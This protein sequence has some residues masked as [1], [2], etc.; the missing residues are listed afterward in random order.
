MQFAVLPTLVL[1]IASAVAQDQPVLAR[2]E[3]RVVDLR[4]EPLPAAVVFV[5]AWS[6][7]DTVLARATAD[8]D[9]RFVLG[10]VPVRDSWGIGAEAPGRTTHRTWTVPGRGPVTVQL[11]EAVRVN[12]RLRN[13]AGEPV[14]GATVVAD[15][16]FARELQG[17]RDLAVTDAEGRFELP[18]VPLGVVSFL[19]VV[20]GEGLALLRRHVTADTVI[21]LSPEGKTVDTTIAVVGLPPAGPP[22]G[23]A[24]N[25]TPFGGAVRALPPPWQRAALARDGRCTLVGLP[26][27]R[28]TV[29][30]E[31]PGFLCHP[32]SARLQPGTALLQFTAVARS[33]PALQ[34]SGY[35][36]D[37][38]GQPVPG[39]ALELRGTN[40]AARA[41]AVTG[42]DGRWRFELPVAPGNVVV[43]RVAAG[44]HVLDTRPPDDPMVLLEARSAAQYRGPAEPDRTL[45][46]RAIRGA[47]VA[48]K[49]LRPDGGPATFAVVRLEESHPTRVPAWFE[50]ARVTTDHD[51]NYTFRGVHPLDRPVRIAVQDPAGAASGEPFELRA[52]GASVVR[53][54][55]QLAPPATVEGDVRDRAGKPVAGLR[56]WLREW[57]V[58]ANKQRSGSLVEVLT[59]SAGRFRFA[60]VAPGGAT[61]QVLFEEEF[62][63]ANAA[64]P[65]EV[66]A[67][68]THRFQLTFAGGP[69][70]PPAAPPIPP[71]APARPPAPAPEPPADER[72]E[73]RVVDLGGEPLAA[74]TVF[75]TAW[76]DPDTVLARAVADGDGRFVLAKVPV[77]GVWG[78]GASAP[79][80]ATNRVQASPGRGPVTVQLPEAVVVRGQLRNRAG[81]PV[82]GATVTASLFHALQGARDLAV[83]DADGRFELARVPLGVVW[84]LAVVPGEGIA[85]LQQHVTGPATIGLAPAPKTVDATIEVAG[86]P[87][88][89]P[90]AGAVVHV[91]AAATG[92]DL[93]PPPWVRPPLDRQGRCVLAGVPEWKLTMTPEIPGY[94]CVPVSALFEFGKVLRFTAV[95]RDSPALR[96]HGQVHDAEG[97]PIAGLALALHAADAGGARTTALTDSDGRWQFV[98]PVAPGNDVVIQAAP[99]AWVLDVQPPDHRTLPPPGREA[100]QYRGKAEPGQPLTLR[101]IRAATVTGRVLR[102]DGRPAALATVRLE[103][104]YPTRTPP[105]IWLAFTTTDHAG[106]YEFRNVHALDR[107]L[108]IAVRDIE[109]AAT[110]QPFDL[111]R[112]GMQVAAPD[113]QLAPGGQVEG[114]VRDPGGKPV[115]GLR[116]R[117]QE[118][119][120]ARGRA[121]GA[122]AEA[123][124]DSA[125][126]FRFRGVAPGA[127]ALQVA[128]AQFTDPKV[129]EPFEVDAGK[130]HSFRLTFVG[131]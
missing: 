51:G 108:R 80:R 1:A 125:G 106:H 104:S 87:A 4:G 92:I 78:V 68:S 44:D 103:E 3:G 46:L 102:A 60:G 15:L 101:A 35:V 112:A 126:R 93:L 28:F 25:L 88:D 69:P 67:G 63:T 118:W 30:P 97:R 43:I 32:V 52:A 131:K 61:L 111:D 62:V 70:V 66:E 34:W 24:V 36:H 16:A 84:F 114:D 110:G 9:G 127:V 96:W 128:L 130:T 8:G 77:C 20:P 11:P 85:G 54:D 57:E 26:E 48:G 56:V 22:A 55:L 53:P 17:V 13:R 5:T 18:R 12:G 6:D 115:P 64:S 75:V 76:T 59:D 113:L 100:S 47:A 40:T 98:L 10:Q 116:V 120:V 29:T 31:I 122:V 39:L 99:G 21:E 123:M 124:T 119:D 72:V 129:E 19:A 41:E 94:L 79:G 7:P 49:V 117:L 109:G 45:M 65:F 33:S 91:S 74:A 107:P 89:G 121:Q 73:G 42:A 95:P 81:K 50:L 2:V 14:A 86:L 82:A 83:S 58:G 90:P 37:P 23:A 27:W 38:A 105:W 71:P